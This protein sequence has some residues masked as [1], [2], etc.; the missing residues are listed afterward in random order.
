MILRSIRHVLERVKSQISDAAL[1][2]ERNKLELSAAKRQNA[3]AETADSFHYKKGKGR[4]NNTS[5]Y[6]LSVR[7]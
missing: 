2:K 6:I 4:I 3:R 1:Q 7:I 5:A